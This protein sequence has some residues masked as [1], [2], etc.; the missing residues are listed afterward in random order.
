MGVKEA[1]LLSYSSYCRTN[2]GEERERALMQSTSQTRPLGDMSSAHAEGRGEQSI[3]L[4][5]RLR[6][7]PGGIERELQ[8]AGS[9]ELV[10][11]LSTCTS[12]LDPALHGSLVASVL[13][14][15]WREAEPLAAVVLDFVQELVGAVPAFVKPCINALV[16]SF[17]PNDK[18]P[19]SDVAEAAA[20]AV[21]PRVHEALRGVLRACPLG[22]G[23]AARPPEPRTAVAPSALLAPR[24][25][26]LLTAR[27]RFGAYGPQ[28][29]LCGH[30]RVPAAPAA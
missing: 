4:Q 24:A 27:S 15:Q 30:Q 10:R 11:V 26:P 6:C 13:G 16:V 2:K 8:A 20:E 12:S 5:A 21:M 17:L 29:P 9:M 14:L 3:D 18:A 23:C 28:R 19:D 25:Q 1:F 22:I 7:D